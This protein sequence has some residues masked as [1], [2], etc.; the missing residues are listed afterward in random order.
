MEKYLFVGGVE[1]VVLGD[2]HV[3]R[4]DELL[5]SDVLTNIRQKHASGTLS[6]FCG[7]CIVFTNSNRSVMKI[8]RREPAIPINSLLLS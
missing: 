3:D 1:D 5:M 8:P 2:L 7:D 6:Q 4:L